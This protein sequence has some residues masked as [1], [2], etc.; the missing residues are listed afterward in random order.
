MLSKSGLFNE[1][2]LTVPKDNSILKLKFLPAGSKRN[3][4]MLDNVNRPVRQEHVNKL[5]GSVAKIGIIRPVV[6]TRYTFNK[7]EDFYILDG[8]NLYHA[9]K[10]LGLDIPYVETKVDSD[11]DLVEQI[12]LMNNSS[13]SWKMKDYVQAWSYIRPDYQKLTTYCS[14]STLEL[15]FIAAVFLGT[16]GW[17]GSV[18]KKLKYG[19]FHIHNETKGKKII[20]YME[21][22]LQQMPVLGRAAHKAFLSMYLR[23][24]MENFSMYD[25]NKFIRYMKKNEKLLLDADFKIEKIEEFFDKY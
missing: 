2:L 12:A 17:S 1:G 8:Q 22:V 4:R 13:K 7:V 25:H 23:F 19:E 21:K 24:V 9:L 14:K 10:K 3:F 20:F 18:V 16:K 15:V 5:A 6:V 11:V